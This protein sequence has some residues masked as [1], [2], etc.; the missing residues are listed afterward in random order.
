MVEISGIEPVV[1]DGP[2]MTLGW[3]DQRGRLRHARAG[4]HDQFVVSRRHRKLEGDPAVLAF[5]VISLSTTVSPSMLI[6]MPTGSSTKLWL[7]I[8]RVSVFGCSV[9]VVASTSGA[10][11]VGGAV[12]SRPRLAWIVTVPIGADTFSSV[13]SVPLPQADVVATRAAIK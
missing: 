5:D 10:C 11:I 4:R 6:V 13:E 1:D 3:D 12:C 7:L 8:W 2:A 9:T